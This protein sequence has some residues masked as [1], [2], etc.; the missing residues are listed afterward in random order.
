MKYTDEWTYYSMQHFTEIFPNLHLWETLT[1]FHVFNVLNHTYH[2]IL[3][4]TAYELKA[5]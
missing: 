5:G 3:T 4:C 1:Q 2:S